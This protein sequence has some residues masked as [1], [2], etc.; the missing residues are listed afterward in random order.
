MST[1]NLGIKALTALAPITPG[2]IVSLASPPGHGALVLLLET[3]HR[4]QGRLLAIGA[5]SRARALGEFDAMFR[6][7]LPPER[8]DTDLMD[9]EGDIEARTT[10]V[11]DALAESL[12][13]PPAFVV[14]D[15]AALVGLDPEVVFAQRAPGRTVILFEALESM[16]TPTERWHTH[17]DVT[18]RFST[19]LARDGV[20]PALDPAR[21]HG[22]G[23]LPQA[24]TLAAERPALLSMYL[25]QP[26]EIAEYYT[27][28][29]GSHVPA[30]VVR[31]DLDRLLTGDLD[32]LDPEAL[33]FKGS[34][35][36]V[37]AV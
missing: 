2:A 9:P 15:V 27:G 1:H 17:A 37:T 33:R 13:D 18:W 3:I 6:D 36:Q 34:L 30:E 24:R 10:R 20:Y 7:G 31:Q 8:V 35:A 25:S 29:P 5:A 16:A 19:E 11:R 4:A 23:A 21:T 28:L 22:P 26:Y 12:E 32:D 14:L